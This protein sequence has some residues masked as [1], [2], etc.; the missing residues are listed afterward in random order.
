MIGKRFTRWKVVVRGEDYIYP[1]N[2][3]SAIRYICEC[4]CGVVKPV[5]SSHLKNGSSQSCGCLNREISTTHGMSKTRAYKSWSGMI[6]RC[7]G[8]TR[9]ADATYAERGITFQESWAD[10]EAFYADMGDCPDGYELERG[11]SFG[12]YCK[13]NCSWT[14]E[15][16]QATNR[17]KFKNNTSGYTGVTWSEVHGKWRVG[18]NVNKKRHEGGLYLDFDKAVAARQQLELKHLGYI[19]EN[20]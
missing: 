15:V 17:A 2:G 10:F 6:Q 20:M 19:K 3:K 4:D 1:H 18:I 9:K 5:H 13:D 14:D 12:N 8:S 7:S 16:T 11:D